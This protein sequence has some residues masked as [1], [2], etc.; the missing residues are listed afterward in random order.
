LSLKDNGN[1]F[2]VTEDYTGLGL[3]LTKNRIS[4]LNSIYKETPFL[5]DMKADED[6]TIINIT[7]SQWL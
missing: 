2:D 5:L 1:G 4:L 6:G 3:A 7:L